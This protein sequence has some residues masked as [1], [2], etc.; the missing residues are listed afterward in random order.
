MKILLVNKY[1]YIKGGAEKY[2]FILADALKKAGHEVI[3]FSMKD[4]RNVP[5][6]TDNYFVKRRDKDGTIFEKAR[7]VLNIKYSREAYKKITKLLNAEKP[8]LV[9]L[10]NIHKQITCSVI[11]AIKDYNKN[12][13]IFWVIH[14]FALA[15]PNYF[16][17]DGHGK[18]C[19]RCLGGDFKNCYIHK[20]SHGSSFMS[21]LSYKEA[22][23][24]R[25]NNFAEKVDLMIC[26]SDFLRKKLLEAHF[27]NTRMITMRNPLT[28]D[29]VAQDFCN[30]NYLLYFGRLSPEKG[31]L[32]L[33]EAVKD[34][35]VQLKVVGE[36]PQMKELREFVTSN[37][38]KNVSFEGYKTGVELTDFVRKSKAVVLPSVWYENGPYSVMEAMLLGKPLIVSKMGGLP[39]LVVD[40]KNGYIFET[41][42]GLK[43][44]IIDMFNL[45]NTEYDE[46]CR[47]SKHLAIELFNPSKYVKQMIELFNEN[48]ENG[49]N[50]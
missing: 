7:M 22:K 36:G 14:D 20:C 31:I 21:R 19:E 37:N 15:C 16:M 46:M 25:K 28:I 2:V 44:A 50:S 6:S 8:D 23:F 12:L 34:L 5:C 48:N 47:F 32:N 3:F 45:T 18:V 1:L 26:P 4:P 10:N 24:V 30:D 27:T 33:I 40:K 49:K 38:V 43:Q 29:D 39:E 42:L 17:L 11:D 35:E 9:I 41:T 13:K